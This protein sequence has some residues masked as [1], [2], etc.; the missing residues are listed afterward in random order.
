MFEDRVEAGKRLARAVKHLVALDPIVLGL[1]RGGVPVANEVARALGAPLD[2]LV[3]R[4]L[5][6]PFQPEFAMGAI[7]EGDVQFIDWE[8]VT[9]AG[10]RPGAVAQVVE[11]ESVEVKRRAD[12]FRAGAAALDLSG[13][14]VVIVDDGIA[15]GSTVTAAV[16]VAREL[17]AEHVVVATP[18]APMEVSGRLRRVADDVVVLETPQNF[19]AVGQAYHDFAQ[20][21]D[22]EVVRILSAASDARSSEH[23]VG[24]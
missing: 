2:V 5:G 19:Y 16:R 14:A 17:G 1:P 4:K 3:V 12:L 11:L 6:I 13:R 18:V 7:G 15:T 20:T 21:E 9:S 23:D 22:D 10:L 8:V 24:R